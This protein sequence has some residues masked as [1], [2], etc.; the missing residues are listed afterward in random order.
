MELIGIFAGLLELSGIYF[1]G[2]KNKIGF[3]T[4]ICGNIL[5]IWF[6]LATGGSYGLLIVCPVASAL[7]IK[8]FIRWRRDEK[9]QEVLSG[10]RITKVK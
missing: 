1:V 2:I 4:A 10:Q 7:N 5:W 6:V 9:K 8:G 3:L